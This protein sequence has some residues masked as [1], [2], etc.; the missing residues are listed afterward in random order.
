MIIGAA[1]G[2]L[3]DGQK[4][5]VGSGVVNI[6]NNYG[7]QDAL[8]K[9]IAKSDELN[10]QKYPLIFYVTAPVT[11]HNGW[12]EV[13]TD[14]VIMMNTK[15]ELLYKDRT[16]KTYV[17]YIEPTY[18]K[19]KQ[20]LSENGYIQVK[21]DLATKWSYTDIANFGLTEATPPGTTSNQSAVTDYVDARV[22][23]LNFR[24]KTDCI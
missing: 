3:L 2:R 21:G 11:E 17:K 14:F 13:T 8:D 12:L 23:R 15:E 5:T 10:A 9:F 19:L 20:L 4:I 22:V 7:N 6:Q 16:V 24:I 18:Q 1:I